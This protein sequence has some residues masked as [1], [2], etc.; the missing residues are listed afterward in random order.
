MLQGG[1]GVLYSTA[2]FSTSSPAPWAGNVSE[3]D[4]RISYSHA[5]ILY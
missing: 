1:M 4:L 5:L 2:M 3:R